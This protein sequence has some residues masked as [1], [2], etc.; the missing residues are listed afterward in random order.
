MHV[1]WLREFKPK[2]KLTSRKTKF[3]VGALISAE[4]LNTTDV[5]CDL[6][7][8]LALESNFDDWT[9]QQL[10]GGSSLQPIGELLLEPTIGY[11]V[12]GLK[13]EEVPLVRSIFRTLLADLDYRIFSGRAVIDDFGDSGED[14]L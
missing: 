9:H 1:N 14:S 8:A 2:S 3:F 4:T 13:S 10:P 5:I 6:E 7:I 12:T 11:W